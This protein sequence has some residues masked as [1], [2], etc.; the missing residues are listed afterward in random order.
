MNPVA[1]GSS[2]RKFKVKAEVRM[3]SGVIFKFPSRRLVNARDEEQVIRIIKAY[4][5]VARGGRF[6]E[7]VNGPVIQ[8]VFAP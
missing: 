8:E 5:A 3:T 4:A 6:K 2:M 7:F 1:T